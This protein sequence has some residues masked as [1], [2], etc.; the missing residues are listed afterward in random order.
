MGSSKILSAPGST[1]ADE[2]SA[3]GM[4]NL[5]ETFNSRDG[6]HLQQ[7]TRSLTYVTAANGR[8]VLS[9]TQN[10]TA[11]IVYIVSPVKAVELGA[12]SPSLTI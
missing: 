7:G 5:T 3:D 11:G 9:M 8:T 4:G 2:L 10:S 1:D 6:T 12:G